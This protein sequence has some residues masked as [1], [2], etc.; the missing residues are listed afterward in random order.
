MVW[1]RHY[2]KINV[3]VLAPHVPAVQRVVVVQL[4]HVRGGNL[5]DLTFAAIN[6]A[7]AYAVPPGLSADAEHVVASSELSAWLPRY[8]Q[9]VLTGAIEPDRPFDGCLKLLDRKTCL[10]WTKSDKRHV[11][12]SLHAIT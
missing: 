2:Y 8:T 10:I 11:A 7:G 3:P 4:P 5:S 9:G 12:E 1:V 6:V